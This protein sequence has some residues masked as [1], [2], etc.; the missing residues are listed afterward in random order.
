M[1]HMIQIWHHSL[2]CCIAIA[3]TLKWEKCKVC[4]SLLSGIPKKRVSVRTVSGLSSMALTVWLSL[5][6]ALSSFVEV[7]SPAPP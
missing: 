6:R 3:I 4:V 5:Y 2:K 7:R 1:F